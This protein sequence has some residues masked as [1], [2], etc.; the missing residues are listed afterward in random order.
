MVDPVLMLPELLEGDAL[1]YLTQNQRNLVVAKLGIDKRVVAN[2]VSAPPGGTITRGSMYILNGAG[3]G[4]WAGQV[5]N[6]IA[7]ALD[8]TPVAADGWFFFVPQ[9]GVTVWV[10]AG[11]PTGHLVWNGSAWTAV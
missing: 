4:L 10:L 2:N 5:A 1:G 6:T 11:S 7:I 9:H 8:A 3:T